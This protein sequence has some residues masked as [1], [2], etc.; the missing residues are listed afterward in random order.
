[1]NMEQKPTLRLKLRNRKQRCAVCNGSGLV[2]YRDNQGNSYTDPCP[3]CDGTGYF[4][5][6]LEDAFATVQE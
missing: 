3:V 4:P 5:E 1:M 6:D 2:G